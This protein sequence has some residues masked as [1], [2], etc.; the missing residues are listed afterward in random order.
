VAHH[1]QVERSEDLDSGERATGV[2]TTAGADHLDD[3]PAGTL[4][5]GSE[6]IVVVSAE[7]Q[8]AI[9]GI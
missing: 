8:I 9:P 7:R 4:R 5:S 6:L 2:A 3:V 1:A